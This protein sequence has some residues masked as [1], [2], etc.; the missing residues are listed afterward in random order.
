VEI[1]GCFCRNGSNLLVTP[2]IAGDE[3]DGNPPDLKKKGLADAGDLDSSFAPQTLVS[4]SISCSRYRYR[5]YLL[6]RRVCSVSNSLSL[7]YDGRM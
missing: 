5:E 2:G 7:A 1:V 6:A 3:E 4:R